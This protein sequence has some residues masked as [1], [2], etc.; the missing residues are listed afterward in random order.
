MVYLCCSTGPAEIPFIH[1]QLRPL[2]LVPEG[3]L[4]ASDIKYTELMLSWQPLVD[5]GNSSLI[6]Y[7]VEKR[8]GKDVDRDRG[9]ITVEKVSPEETKCHVI[10]LKAGTLYWFRVSAQNKRGTGQPLETDDLVLT[11]TITGTLQILQN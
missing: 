3:P 8:E 4:I 5:E 2:L 7:I 6:H 10:G 11:K 1:I 9:W